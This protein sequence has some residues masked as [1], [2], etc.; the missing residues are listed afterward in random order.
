MTQTKLTISFTTTTTIEA[1]NEINLVLA[2][3]KYKARVTEYDLISVDE[4]ERY[5][6]D[7]IFHFGVLINDT[8]DNISAKLKGTGVD[9]EKAEE[10]EIPKKRG[11]FNR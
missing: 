10:L 7:S 9:I 6:D 4:G 2:S 1:I 11:I 8:Y 5:F 3:A